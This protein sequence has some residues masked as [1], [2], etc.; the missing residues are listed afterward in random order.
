MIARKRGYDTIIPIRLTCVLAVV[1]AANGAELKTVFGGREWRLSPECRIEGGILTVTV[2]KD[3][4]RGLHAPETFRYLS[5]LTLTNIIYQVHMYSPSDFTHQRVMDKRQWS[6]A[7]P[8]VE[9]GWNIDYL[10]NVMKPVREFQF[11]HKARIYVGEFSAV[12]WAE[13]AER[14]LDD[15]IDNPRKRVLLKG[16]RRK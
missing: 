2:P 13:G 1:C 15:C 16:F 14:Y 7:Y 10:R 4:A 9:K 8:N 6:V 5:P 11:K 3:R 12:A